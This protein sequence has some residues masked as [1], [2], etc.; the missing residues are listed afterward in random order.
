MFFFLLVYC[1]MCL[2]FVH[3][4]AIHVHLLYLAFDFAKQN[5]FYEITHRPLHIIFFIVNLFK[6]F[7]CHFPPF[8]YVFFSFGK[9]WGGQVVSPCCHHHRHDPV[10]ASC[11]QALCLVALGVM[12]PPWK[13]LS[14]V[15]SSMYC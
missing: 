12:P 11:R 7:H 3:Y 4:F 15:A 13:C 5:V 10:L 2:P 6:C 14:F 9:L 8:C 1:L